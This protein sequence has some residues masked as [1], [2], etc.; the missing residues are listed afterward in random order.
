MGPG[1]ICGAL[2]PHHSFTEAHHVKASH[3]LTRSEATACAVVYRHE[4]TVRP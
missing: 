1:D 3:R 2:V 4:Y